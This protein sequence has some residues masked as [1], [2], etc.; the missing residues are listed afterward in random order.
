MKYFIYLT[1]IYFIFSFSFTCITVS[2]PYLWLMPLFLVVSHS[3]GC[4][5][6]ENVC[7]CCGLCCCRRVPWDPSWAR[8]DLPSCEYTL[9]PQC[10]EFTFTHLDYF[11]VIPLQSPLLLTHHLSRY[12]LPYIYFEIHISFSCLLE[13]YSST[14]PQ[15]QGEETNAALG[16]FAR[17]YVSFRGHVLCGVNGLFLA[18]Q[19]RTGSYCGSLCLLM[20]CY[21]T[22]MLL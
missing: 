3:S 16:A 12:I 11:Q 7:V 17:L 22:R 13:D 2:E 15:Q 6:A 14:W 9:Q 4:A 8:I 10:T 19:S 5:V 1:S 18:L 20:Y 21:F